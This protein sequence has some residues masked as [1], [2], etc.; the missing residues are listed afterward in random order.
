QSQF[1]VTE[2]SGTT[3]TGNYSARFT[4]DAGNL[5]VSRRATPAADTWSFLDNQNT[6]PGGTSQP[7]SSK[8]PCR[9]GTDYDNI[10]YH[11]LHIQASQTYYTHFNRRQPFPRQE[12]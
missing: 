4:A 10:I 8:Y 6:P 3:P 9:T 2:R 5:A 1:A 12:G 11:L 7:E